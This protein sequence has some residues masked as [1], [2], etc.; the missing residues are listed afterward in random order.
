VHIHFVD[1]VPGG[2]LVPGEGTLSLRNWLR[3][4]DDYGYGVYLSLEI[5]DR[6]YY[7][8]P[9]AAD[10]KSRALIADWLK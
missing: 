3:T 8:E 5:A 1:G 4:L 7:L 10:R 6:R 2:H 9:A